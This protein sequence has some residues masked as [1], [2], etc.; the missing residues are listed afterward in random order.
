MPCFATTPAGGVVRMAEN[1]VV[2]VLPPGVGDH[3]PPTVAS[4]PGFQ[5]RASHGL[6]T[7]KPTAANGA[8]SRV[9]TMRSWAAAIAAT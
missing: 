8:V 6:M 3:H 7:V 2:P 5:W 9:A 4:V 1:E